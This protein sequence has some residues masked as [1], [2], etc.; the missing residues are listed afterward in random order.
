M[1]VRV[2]VRKFSGH[3]AKRERASASRS[4]HRYI[5]YTHLDCEILSLLLMR[6]RIPLARG[7]KLMARWL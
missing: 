5:K 3:Q 4:I 7:P 6:I 1:Q 2:H